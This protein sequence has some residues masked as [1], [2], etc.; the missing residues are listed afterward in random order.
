[1]SDMQWGVSQY[2]VKVSTKLVSAASII[3]L[4]AYRYNL[5]PHNEW[6]DLLVFNNDI[7]IVV[8]NLGLYTLDMSI[9]ITL[10]SNHSHSHMSYNVAQ[11]DIKVYIH[12][13]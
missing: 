4:H 10:C 13:E 9:K 1:M 2:N 12:I 3:L 8:Y 6:N 5:S 11:Y 7:S